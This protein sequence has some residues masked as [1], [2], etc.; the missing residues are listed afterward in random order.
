LVLAASNNGSLDADSK[1]SAG[2]ILNLLTSIIASTTPSDAAKSTYLRVSLNVLDRIRI[3]VPEAG[4][5]TKQLV[6]DLF[7]RIEQ[8]LAT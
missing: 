3:H 2:D 4:D 1:D 8:L 7:T 5:V 6:S